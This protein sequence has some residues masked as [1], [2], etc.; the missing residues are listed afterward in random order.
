MTREQGNRSPVSQAARTLNEARENLFRGAPAMPQRPARAPGLDL[1]SPEAIAAQH[2]RDQE[3]SPQTAN[4]MR[5]SYLSGVSGTSGALSFLSGYT[6]DLHLD[7]PKIFTSKQV[8][9][10]RLQQAEVVHF[11][12]AGA[13]MAQAQPHAQMSGQALGGVPGPAPPSAGSSTANLDHAKL[14]PVVYS[15][16][17]IEGAPISP[18][19]SAV[20]SPYGQ[21]QQYGSASESSP[22]GESSAQLP[23]QLTPSSSR[24]H[25]EHDYGHDAEEE[26]PSPD[27]PGDLRF[28]MG[29]LA[30]RNSVSSMGTSRS[31]PAHDSVIPPTPQGHPRS[32]YDPPRA[33]GVA[34]QASGSG[35]ESMMSSRSDGSGLSGFP[36]IG[37]GAR[38]THAANHG[39]G[40]QYQYQTG[41]GIPQSTSVTTLDHAQLGS[42]P[43]IEH[44]S[45]ARSAGNTNKPPTSYKPVVEPKG[46]S[47]QPTSQPQTRAHS[48]ADSFLGEF[49]F[50]SPNAGDEQALPSARM[51]QTAAPNTA[52]TARQAGAGAG[53]NR[54][55]AMS[56][57]SEGLGAFE[58]RLGPGMEDEVPE[59][60]DLPN[61]GSR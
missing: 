26:L 43:H 38:S 27:R 47:A 24:S 18:A 61:Q 34:A 35:R 14:S 51:P 30:Y 7:A 48:V 13:A 36:M 16:P 33:A 40:Q 52:A 29:S 3:R 58:F 59:V 49:P 44:M 11:G 55:T 6:T 12:A 39:A 25:H 60:P 53:A 56:V 20:R 1:R 32:P 31:R 50:R 46:R 57:A 41:Q 21:Q 54:Y 42:H 28:S 10:G 23:R 2:E 5:N 22:Y 15:P 45:T 4:T 9:I 8:Q 17:H 19:L 37:P